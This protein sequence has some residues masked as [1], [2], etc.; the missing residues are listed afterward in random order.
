MNPHYLGW[1][2]IARLGLVQAA[3]GSIVV[4]TTSTM[5]RVMVVELAL[6]A[7]VP[8]ALVALH[9]LIQVL[10]PRLGYGSDVG[11]RRTPWIIGGMLV[12]AL[13]G[14]GAAAGT[15]LMQTHLG[16]GLALAVVSFSLIGIGVGASGTSMLVL[17][18]TSVHP[19]RRAAAATVTWLTMIFGFVLTTAIAGQFLDPFSGARLVM[20]T[21]CVCLIAFA[22]TVLAV[23]GIE[24]AARPGPAADSSNAVPAPR[25]LQALAQVWNETESRRLA[26]FVFVSMIA[27]SAQDL[28]L[29]PFAGAVFGLTPGES[30]RLSSMQNGGVLVGMIAVAVLATAVGGARLG[31][32]RTW[33][34]GGCLASAAALASLAF[35]A[36]VGPAWPLRGSVFV[37]GL[38]NGAFAVAAIGSMMSAVDAGRRG[39]EGVRMGLWG[40]AQ[41]VAFAIGGLV[42]T[43][44]TDLARWLLGSPAAAYACVFIAEAAL[45]VCAALLAR[46]LV[47]RAPAPAAASARLG[48]S[49]PT[50]SAAG[51]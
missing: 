35:A 38:A 49:M 27:Y 46:N 41:A 33:T 37:L 42:G 7:L 5:N 21:S 4:M 24:S 45:F 12:L 40:A 31:S 6:P 48:G 2:G 39:R 1:L 15:A 19:H 34:I 18:A 20:V 8:G 29:E 9:Y 43:A 47:W 36:S 16:A 22:V 23:R 44:A 26:I 32:M 51:H 13:G 17:M 14:I 11:R 10:R 25:F 3:L 28:I 50:P 30:T